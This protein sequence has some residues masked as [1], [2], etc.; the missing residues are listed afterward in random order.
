MGEPGPASA[1][2]RKGP[3]RAAQRAMFGSIR[4]AQ[5]INR[6]LTKRLAGGRPSR[7]RT[8]PCDSH[9]AKHEFR[10]RTGRLG[11]DAA[12]SR[13]KNETPPCR[14]SHSI[15]TADDARMAPS[16]RAHHEF[17]YG[18]DTPKSAH[19]TRECMESHAVSIR[20]GGVVACL[21]ALACARGVAID[22]RLMSTARASLCCQWQAEDACLPPEIP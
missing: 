6:P 3:P 7:P 19:I 21:V 4:R 5:S 10:G 14:S 11:A 15:G 9:A 20:A 13:A 2:P 16:S 22:R 1:R 12:Q 18:C 17:Y 8:R